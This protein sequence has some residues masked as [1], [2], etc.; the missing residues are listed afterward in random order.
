MRGWNGCTHKEGK[1]WENDDREGRRM[2][3]WWR[4]RPGF[5]HTV[6]DQNSLSFT[7]TFTSWFVHCGESFIWHKLSLSDR[8]HCLNVLNLDHLCLHIGVY[9][10]VLLKQQLIQTGC[11]FAIHFARPTLSRSF[12][13]FAGPVSLMLVEHMKVFSMRCQW[14]GRNKNIWSYSRSIPYS[15]SKSAFK[16][17]RVVFIVFINIKIQYHSR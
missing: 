13:T 9:S 8:S 7:M 10:Q 16:F 12:E 15:K 6:L 4:R 14:H 17:C 2:P 1:R 3:W 5:L 11:W